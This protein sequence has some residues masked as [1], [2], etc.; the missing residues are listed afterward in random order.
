[1]L[2]HA[3]YDEV[4]QLSQQIYAQTHDPDDLETLIIAHEYI[5]RILIHHHQYTEAQ[6]NCQQHR[7]LAHDLIYIRQSPD[8]YK[9]YEMALRYAAQIAEKLHDHDQA[10]AHWKEALVYA[11]RII[12]LRESIFDLHDIAVIN[13]A[14]G[15]LYDQQHAY[16]EAIPYVRNA[17]EMY[18]RLLEKENTT[19]RIN[20]FIACAVRLGVCLY[21]TQSFTAVIDC[22]TD[23]V[24]QYRRYQAVLPDTTATI[25]PEIIA[26]HVLLTRAY[27]E[28][29][30]PGDAQMQEQ[31]IEQLIV[32]QQQHNLDT[33]A[34]IQAYDTWKNI[35]SSL[36]TT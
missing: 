22:L 20:K 27:M 29:A 16:A 21:A 12:S 25:T 1:M 36:P 6:Q 5:T 2:N 19:Y 4:L 18:K 17:Y 26:I 33:S 11:N 32:T 23:T 13:D 35:L 7:M 34:L 24:N 8:D 14:I 15:T 3:V 10:I 9:R 28:I 31:Y 30:Q